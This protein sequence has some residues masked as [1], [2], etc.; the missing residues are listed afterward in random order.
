MR[1][2]DSLDRFSSLQGGD[3][4]QTGEIPELD[5]RAA[6]CDK[7]R[8]VRRL[9]GALEVTGMGV[10]TDP[11]NA[12]EAIPE[13]EVS[14]LSTAGDDGLAIAGEP[15]DDG[16]TAMSGPFE[17][18]VTRGEIPELERAL[19]SD[20][21]QSPA[22]RC[23]RGDVDFGLIRPKGPDQLPGSGIPDADEAVLAGSRQPVA[24]GGELDIIDL[25]TKTS[26]R[27]ARSIGSPPQAV[28]GEFP[29]VLLVR[30]RSM[31]SE[32]LERGGCP[33]PRSRTW[34][35]ECQ[36]CTRRGARPGRGGAPSLALPRDVICLVE[37]GLEPVSFDREGSREDRGED[38]SHHGHRMPPDLPPVS[39]PGAERSR[40]RRLA[41]QESVEVFG[42]L[43]G[44]GYRRGG[45]FSRHFRRIPS[46][47]AGMSRR[48]D[49]A[50]PDH[51][52]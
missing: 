28:P 49:E 40:S 3:D 15:G 7:D 36:R 10:N 11:F 32:P 25:I 22:I 29:K 51:P 5:F 8:A 26:Q 13:L 16:V 12:L 24:V 41:G 31:P 44:V 2:S 19:I 34:P 45:T 9:D 50:E 14:V 21:G 39:L 38:Q 46:S 37:P 30:A 52:R 48:G 6:C 23:K 42:Q 20:R 47:A 18:A 27:T 43:A 33:D 35:V 17:P 1:E 4:R